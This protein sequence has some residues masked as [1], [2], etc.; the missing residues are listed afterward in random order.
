MPV[1][2]F[3]AQRR[4]VRVGR[5]TI[6]GVG[7]IV[8]PALAGLPSLAVITLA[9]D[10][11]ATIALLDADAHVLVDD[12][13]LGSE[14]KPL[15]DGATLHIGE[16][17]LVYRLE[18]TGQLPPASISA[19]QSVPETGSASE[20]AA[21]RLIDLQSGK[22]HEI[23][24]RGMVIGR[25]DDCDLVIP[26]QGVS[27]RHAVIR[28][29]GTGYTVTDESVNGTFV[30][31]SRVEGVQTLARGDKLRIGMTVFRLERPAASASS[32]AEE[33]QRLPAVALPEGSPDAPAAPE[34]GNAPRR[35]SGAVAKELAALEVVR[36]TFG[37]NRF[38]ITRAVCS[39]GRTED[40]DIVIPHD[41]VSSSHATLLQ[42]ADS[43]YVVDL[44]S[45]NGT[46][47]DGYRVA[48]ERMLSAGSVL[49][50]GQVKMIFWP[51]SHLNLETHGTQPLLGVFQ[52]LAKRILNR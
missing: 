42:K 47:V 46:F 52:Q 8:F 5:N 45:A 7:D 11:E 34:A 50:V 51:A 35:R 24:S 23:P 49:T 43:W 26:T 28:R 20:D 19:G 40:N 15:R 44:R 48:G 12:A 1:L 3:G 9:A 32:S 21:W 31:D 37:S 41:S 33:T 4:E 13:L 10:G 36:G 38:S 17:D 2:I 18:S 6:G 29:V 16:R 39:I 25:D 27:R 14:P 22:I 30:N